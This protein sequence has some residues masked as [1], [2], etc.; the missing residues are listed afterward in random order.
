MPP[1][2]RSGCHL[3]VSLLR[4]I[5]GRHNPDGSVTLYATTAT[6]SGSGD[7]GADPNKLVVIADQPTA[8]TPAV[9]DSIHKPT[10]RP[11]RRS[12]TRSPS[13]QARAW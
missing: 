7:N 8:T 4:A 10:K 5:T 6:I 11:S 2:Y 3:E 13:P 9:N 1:K 12:P